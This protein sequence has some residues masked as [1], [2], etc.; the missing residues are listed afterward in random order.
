MRIIKRASGSV[1]VSGSV[2]AKAKTRA[3]AVHPEGVSRLKGRLAKPLV[4]IGFEH[5]GEITDAGNRSVW[6]L[7]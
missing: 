1:E 6:I 2:C 7:P 5:S 4:T 3:A